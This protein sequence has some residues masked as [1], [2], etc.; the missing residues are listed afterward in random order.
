LDHD[1]VNWSAVANEFTFGFGLSSVLSWICFWGLSKSP[2]LPSLL[3]LFR[4]L[5]FHCL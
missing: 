2:V 5:N 3:F 4:I 1:V